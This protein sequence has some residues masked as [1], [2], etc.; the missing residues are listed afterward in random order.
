[1][2]TYFWLRRDL[3]IKENVGLYHCLKE[4][5]Q[6]Q[7]IFIFDNNILEELPANDA[8][9]NF[10]YDELEKIQSHLQKKGSSL[11]ILKGNPEN[12]YRELS[13]N[14]PINVYTNHDYEPYAIKRDQTIEEI[15]KESGGVFKSFKNQVIFEKS[16]V[17]KQD[18]KPYTVYTPYKN[19]WLENFSNE[20]I[21]L[22]ETK[23]FQDKFNQSNFDFP[24]RDDLNITKSEI[25]VLDWKSVSI[26]YKETRDFPE[27]NSTSLL[28]PHLRFGTVSIRELVMEYKNN[29]TFLS[30]LIWREFFMQILYHFPNSMKANFKSKYDQVE[31]RNNEHE[32][33]QWKK[34]QTGYPIVDAGIRELLKTGYM[35]NRV[36]M[37]VAGFLCKHLLVDWRIGEAFFA[38]H[39][40]DYEMSSNVGN[41]QWAAGTG[42]D[43][44][45]YFRIFNPITQL[46]KFDKDF[47]YINRWIE[48]LQELTYPTPMVEHKYARSRCLEAYKTAL[49]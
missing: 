24:S 26:D 2:Q 21:K 12:V 16:E 38:E 3:N 40:L 42:C 4:Y 27:L 8:R 25:K 10:I 13:K 22:Y 15:I 46:Q 30:E 41:W 35:H 44:A 29:A 39:L 33:E 1:M 49:E 17:V 20:G 11:K 43:A 47:K 14:E 19:K 6:V 36:R 5:D 23:S 45:P 9:V 37:I 34:G 32:I 31:W 18:N 28:S 48:D 7:L